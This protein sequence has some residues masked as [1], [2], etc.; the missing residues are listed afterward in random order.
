MKYSIWSWLALLP[1]TLFSQSQTP[2]TPEFW[3][4][5]STEVISSGHQRQIIPKKYLNC[6]LKDTSFQ[7]YLFKAPNEKEVSVKKS[8][9]LIQ[10]PSPD[11]KLQTFRVVISSIMEKGLADKFPEIQTFLLKG[12]DDAYAQGRADW[13]P[14]GF[15]AMIR[16][17]KGDFFIDPYDTGTQLRYISYYTQDF[18]KDPD[19][20][21][22]E[23]GVEPQGTETSPNGSPEKKKVNL[24][25]AAKTAGA[26]CVGT[27][28]R[29]YRLAVACTGEYAVA[30]TGN[31]SP[32][33]A[34]A[35][36][37]IVTSINRVNT[38]Y[39]SEV[40]VR[41]VLVNNNNSV[42]F[43]N[44]STD[45]FSGNNNSNVLIGES[46]TVITSGIG[47][48]NFDIGHT[49]STG[50][51]GLAQLGCVC[52][53][54][55]KARGIT[56]SAQPTGDPYDIDYV[57][58][59]IGHQ[60]GGNHTF[61]STTGSCAGN[62]NAG[63]SVEPGSGITIMAYAGLCNGTNNIAGNSIPY[64]HAESYDE[65]INFVTIGGGRT[66]A[67]LSPTLNNPPVVTAPTSYSM[68]FSTPFQLTG[69]A[70]DQ[71][72]DAIT[73]SWEGMDVGS[74][75]GGNWNSGS[76][77]FFRSYA[78]VTDS[79]RLFPRLSSIITGS[80]NNIK[81]EYLPTS[82]QTL[83][84][85]LTARDNSPGGAGVCYKDVQVVLAN[86]GPLAVTKPNIL[87]ITWY[88][89]GVEQ[90]TWDVNNVNQ[91]PV[92]CTDVKIEY[93]IDGG[94]TFIPFIN[95]TPNDG[96]EW[97]NVPQVSG[98][99]TD[100]RIRIQC[101]NAPAFDINNQNFTIS[102][103]VNRNKDIDNS[104]W[105][106]VLP[107]PFEESF[108]LQFEGNAPIPVLAI[109][110]EDVTGR[111]IWEE[112]GS[113]VELEKAYSTAQLSPGIYWLRLLGASG[114]SVTRLIKQ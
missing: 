23:A 91:A 56:G 110:L 11:G 6:Q 37:R 78:P 41:L 14:Q 109:Q 1:F 90:I 55:T 10:I 33:V 79:F 64:F 71:D 19:K 67:V 8:Q 57:A 81:G 17:P 103:L 80:L 38:V 48:N 30:A 7:T 13:G 70:T 2:T 31:P 27:D 72:G 89:Q 105:V 59:E 24:D 100:C 94:V 29:T 60:F 102:T 61:N 3:Q 88:Q 16:S 84:F 39:E 95:S 28:L 42:V 92:N 65:I 32:T 68:P 34:Q 82:A 63:T 54:S 93:S 97:I 108:S 45:P 69:S 21:I 43:T 47:A 5:N 51:G 44:A 86:S 74:G 83:N 85:R 22:P 62:R 77:P 111:I 113:S 101:L 98:T 87:G 106:K 114:Q 40:A 75:A 12:V 25:V 58:H 112:K 35:L 96:S 4:L 99:E 46:Q 9:Y 53:G 36:A 26:S 20:I 49:F 50:G 76:K 18:E 15:H 66:C 107:N 73:Y 52:N 104:A